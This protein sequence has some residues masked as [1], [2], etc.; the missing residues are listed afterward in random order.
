[1]ISTGIRTALLQLFNLLQSIIVPVTYAVAGAVVD[2]RGH[3]LL[4]KHSYKLGWQLPLGGVGRGEAAS[5]AVLR[6]LRE[7]IGLTEGTAALFA[8]YTRR[9][10]WAT[11]VIALFRITGATINFSPNLE[12]R[13][14]MFID[15]ALPPAECTD[16]TRRRLDELAGTVPLSPYW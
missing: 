9:S 13:D 7:E 5:E 14:I 1:L 2:K 15:P 4:V 11:N 8:I 16:D 6:E 3:I 10:G 12:I